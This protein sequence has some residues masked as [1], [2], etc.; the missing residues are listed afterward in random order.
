MHQVLPKPAAVL[1]YQ[2]SQ[3]VPAASFLRV[4]HSLQSSIVYELYS[5]VCMQVAKLS[6]FLLSW[7][8]N[9]FSYPK[10]MVGTLDY[11][12]PEVFI[13]NGPSKPSELTHYDYKVCGV[14]HKVSGQWI[15][16]HVAPQEFP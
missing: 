9:R 7:D 12:A 4:T 16:Q 11:V 15:G 10:D 5:L 3:P 2:T 14:T 8:V 1:A 6:G 13:L